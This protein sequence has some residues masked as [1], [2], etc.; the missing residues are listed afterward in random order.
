MAQVS[1]DSARGWLASGL[2]T[3]A[4]IDRLREQEDVHV[5][6]DPLLRFV[7]SDCLY[8]VSR[9]TYRGEGG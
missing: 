6:Y 1:D 5:R 9:M 7:P 8:A 2:F 3:R 4:A